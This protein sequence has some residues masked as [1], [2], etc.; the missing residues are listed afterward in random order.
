MILADVTDRVVAV[1]Q[2]CGLERSKFFGNVE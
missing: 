2:A 1:A